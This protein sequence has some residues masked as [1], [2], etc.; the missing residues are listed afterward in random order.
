MRLFRV[1]TQLK[2]Q[3]QIV[4]RWVDVTIPF[5]LSATTLALPSDRYPLVAALS[6]P[7][8]IDSSSEDEDDGDGETREQPAGAAS[9][10]QSML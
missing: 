5:F 3:L 4:A 2:G 6:K 7:S 10:R 1:Q 9:C 8:S